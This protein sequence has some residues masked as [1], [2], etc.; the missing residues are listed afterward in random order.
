MPQLGLAEGKA[1]DLYE[2][3][4]LL[5][6]LGIGGEILRMY[7]AGR[8]DLELLAVIARHQREE[9]TGYGNGPEM[10]TEC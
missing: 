6:S 2:K 3:L 4:G 5:A 9:N 7:D 1:L 8:N 10:D